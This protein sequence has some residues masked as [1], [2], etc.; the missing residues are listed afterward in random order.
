MMRCGSTSWKDPNFKRIDWAWG[1]YFAGGVLV[2]VISCGCYDSDKN[3][4]VCVMSMNGKLGWFPR[5]NGFLVEA[6][7]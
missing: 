1:S 5:V 2:T 4:W 3:P 7:K 6:N